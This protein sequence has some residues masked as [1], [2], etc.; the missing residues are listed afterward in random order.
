LFTHWWETSRQHMYDPLHTMDINAA[1]RLVFHLW[2]SK[3]SKKKSKAPG[4]TLAKRKFEAHVRRRPRA[5]T[6]TFFLPS[7]HALIAQKTA[8]NKERPDKQVKVPG[9]SSKLVCAG[10]QLTRKDLDIAVDRLMNQLH[11]ARMHGGKFANAFET[12]GRLYARDNRTLMGPCLAWVLKGVGPGL[13][14]AARRAIVDLSWHLRTSESSTFTVDELQ[15]LKKAA[16][17]TVS[18]AEKA[19]PTNF[20]T[21]STHQLLHVPE[22]IYEAGAC[23]YWW[24]Y[25]AERFMGYICR[26]SNSRKGVCEGV[27]RRYLHVQ[28][29]A[30]AEVICPA[31][32]NNRERVSGVKA[33]NPD[34]DAAWA[35]SLQGHAQRMTTHNLPEQ[36]DR[37]HS[38]HQRVKR[39][40]RLL[41]VDQGP[42]LARLLNAFW[43]EELL[44]SD[45]AKLEKD[46]IAKDRPPLILL[47]NG[48]YFFKSVTLDKRCIIHSGGKDAVRLTTRMHGNQLPRTEYGTVIHI[49]KHAVAFG[50]DRKEMEGY[51]ALISLGDLRRHKTTDF[52]PWVEESHADSFSG[53][54][55]LTHP[56]KHHDALM[57]LPLTAIHPYNVYFV[58]S[59][60]AIY[61][62]NVLDLQQRRFLDKGWGVGNDA[63]VDDAVGDGEA[64]AEG[65]GGVIAAEVDDQDDFAQDDV[66]ENM[67]GQLAENQEA[68]DGEE[69]EGDG[70]DAG[71]G[72]NWGSGEDDDPREEIWDDEAPPSSE[73]DNDA[74]E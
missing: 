22:S 27:V 40:D 12:P 71:D 61:N 5:F 11:M 58:P 37:A 43:K 19:L 2:P 69:N 31:L 60:N 50:E 46:R 38:S 63:A 64:A 41:T 30:E 42:I 32:F 55:R 45:W 1:K 7:N 17:L 28:A 15:R 25:G 59:G 62:M 3:G 29:I 67:W 39:V 57:V 48:A 21:I 10:W 47:G 53:L 51:F 8:Q 26:N 65:V 74:D 36:M 13:S 9:V 23:V 56:W 4:F 68:A 14:V 20:A 72:D 52:D 44:G 54:P 49:F 73:G 6:Q 33:S 16:F 24:L 34:Y 70:H 18:Q 66:E 35:G